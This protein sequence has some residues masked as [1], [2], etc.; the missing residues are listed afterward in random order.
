M[1]EPKKWLTIATTLMVCLHQ[2]FTALSG[3]SSLCK[4][5]QAPMPIGNH[6]V[7]LHPCERRCSWMDFFATNFV[8]CMRDVAVLPIL[9]SIMADRKSSTKKLISRLKLT[10]EASYANISSQRTPRV[11]FAKVV[12][13]QYKKIV[14]KKLLNFKYMSMTYWGESG[15]D[16]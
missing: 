10:S 14:K 8:V 11:P 5:I 1:C 12:N 4:I 7:S 3:S 16:H 6:L 2:A 13:Q 15:K 9:V